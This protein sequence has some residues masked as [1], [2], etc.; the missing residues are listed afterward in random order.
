MTKPQV[1]DAYARISD[2]KEGDA[3]GVQNQLVAIRKWC[4]KRGYTLADT[5]VD[6][7][8]SATSGKTRP[9]FEALL[10][11]TEHRPV[12][13]WHTDRLARVSR[14]MERV[15]DTQ[16]LVYS[17]HAGDLD[18]STINGQAMAR[19]V[20]A[21]ATAEIQT[22]S[23]R[24]RLANEARA[25]KGLPYWRRAPFGHTK[26][27]QLVEA[28][29]ALIRKAVERVLEG[30]SLGSIARE[31][32]AAGVQGPQGAREWDS[33]RVRTVLLN[34]RLYGALIFKGEKMPESAIVPIVS[35]QDWQALKGFLT[36]PERGK[37]GGPIANLGT[38][39]YRCGTCD[40]G[41]AVHGSVA[42]LGPRGRQELVKTY[43][44]SKG[45]H[46]RWVREY[47]DG[48]VVDRTLALLT[49]SDAPSLLEDS[50][51]GTQ[52]AAEATRLREE[53]AMW[54]AEA[55]SLGTAEYLAITRPI[56]DALEAA[57][58]QMRSTN[59]AGIFAGLVEPGMGQWTALLGLAEAVERWEAL[60]LDRKRAIID[61]T[62]IITLLPRTPQ[63]R[64]TE[65]SIKDGIRLERR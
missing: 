46:N 41:T 40:D 25:I 17:V 28:E 23:A 44:C 52:A 65:Q 34:E 51:K 37:G 43:R 11:R 2:D 15:L 7:S 48:Y 62:W 10:S 38:S 56:K 29:A 36:A 57:E 4:S 60:D 39:I 14:D 24:A 20:T 26:D 54:R 22:K 30:G 55:R 27:G 33:R 16:M 64:W 59:R 8:V 21:M 1:V 19:M 9:E 32:T 50:S 49:S 42:L 58:A 6:N 31:W 47:A 18:L 13:V 45:P 53:L 35:E 61:A 12:V 5:Y 3:V 63:D